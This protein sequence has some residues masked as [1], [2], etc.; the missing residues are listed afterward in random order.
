MSARV[1]DLGGHGEPITPFVAWASAD[2][3]PVRDALGGPTPLAIELLCDPPTIVQR[4]LDPS[5]VAGTVLGALVVMAAA[6]AFF[7]ATIAVVRD[8]PATEVATSAG[9]LAFNALLALAAALGP[10]YATGVLVAARLPLS[11]LVAALV[12]AAAS[13]AMILAAL[14]PVPYGLFQVDP[15]WAGP[16]S[17]VGAFAIAAIAS[18]RRLHQLLTLIAAAVVSQVRGPDTELSDGERFRV[19]IVARMGMTFL[20]FT[21]ALAMWAF[22]VL[23]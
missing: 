15:E 6:T 5:R 4:L 18:G 17:V 8:S 12:A 13:G 23:V 22:D 1:E 16:L 3:A 19:G 14:A 7:G 10:I 21:S 11:R 20:A 2:R 9:L